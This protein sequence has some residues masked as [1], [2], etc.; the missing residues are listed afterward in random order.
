MPDPN[1]P[2][3]DNADEYLEYAQNRIQL[4]E[5]TIHHMDKIQEDQL[6]EIMLLRKKVC[7]FEEGSVRFSELGVKKAVEYFDNPP[8]PNDKLSSAAYEHKEKGYE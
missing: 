2:Q 4:L 3:I 5:E 6:T 8:E 1:M 7:E